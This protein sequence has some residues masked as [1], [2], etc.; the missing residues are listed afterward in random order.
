MPSLVFNWEIHRVNHLIGDELAYDPRLEAKLLLEKVGRL[1]ADQRACYKKILEAIKAKKEIAHFF[2]FIWSCRYW[3]DLS[4][5]HTMSF[6]FAR[7]EKL[8]YVLHYLE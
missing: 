2:F 4:I 1:N 7:R 3:K 6:F 5:S 8:F